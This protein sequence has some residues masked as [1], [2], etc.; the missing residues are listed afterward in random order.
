[1]KCHKA[2]EEYLKIED[3][4]QV[5]FFLKLHIITCRDCR[6]EISRLGKLFELIG[7]DSIYK[8]RSTISSSVMDVI[9]RESIYSAKTIS[10]VKW[11][12]IG[13][14]IFIS[15][16]LI[17]FSESFVWLKNEFGSDYTVP[18]SIVMGFVLS[19]YS[20]VVIGCNYE[21]IKKY[22]HLHSKWKFK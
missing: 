2:V 5:P 15:I 12:T 1:M 20:A 13:T 3:Y 18:L 8:S 11:V 10:G 17:N 22:I 19:A 9:R 6:N 4:N 7:K 21:E 16:L 14:V